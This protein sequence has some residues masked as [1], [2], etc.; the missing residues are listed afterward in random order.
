M[1]RCIAGWLIRLAIVCDER[2]DA[3]DCEPRRRQISI[4]AIAGRHRY[5]ERD[6]VEDAAA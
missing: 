2:T 3:N 1:R 6:A 4:Y 5:E